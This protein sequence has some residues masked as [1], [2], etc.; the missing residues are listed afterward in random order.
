LERYCGR[1]PIAKLLAIANLGGFLSILSILRALLHYEQH[2][3]SPVILTL[4]LGDNNNP[5]NS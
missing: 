4:A 5:S 3:Y 1:D 2:K